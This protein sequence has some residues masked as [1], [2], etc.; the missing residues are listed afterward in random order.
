MAVGKA[1]EQLGKDEEAK[2]SYER[3]KQLGWYSELELESTK[4][5]L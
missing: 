2:E 3:A 5:N 1:L 4:I